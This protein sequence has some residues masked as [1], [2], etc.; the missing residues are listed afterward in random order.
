V[1]HEREM[2]RAL[3][4][5][6][7]GRGRVSPN[8][9]VGALVVRDGSVVAEG[10]HEGPGLAHA[11]AAALARAGDAARGATVYSTL[12]PCDHEGRTPPCTNALISAGVRRV[13][14][15][16]QDPNPLVDGG[17]IARL[18]RAGIDVVTGVLEDESHRLNEAFDKHVRTGLPF[19][20]LKMAAS[21]DGKV[22]ASDG[23]SRW[24][25]GPESRADA[26]A[27]RSVSDAIGVGAGTALADDPYL[28]ARDVPS[29]GRIPLRVLVDARGR[30]PA[31][32]NLFDGS[33]PTL[34]ATTQ[35]APAQRRA[36]WEEFGAQVLVLDEAPGGVDVRALMEALGK[37]DVQGLV[38]E[39]GP[40]LAWSFV[41]AGLI[42]KVILYLG[43]L[44]VGGSDA[45]TVLG[46]RGF[47]PL[48]EAL[49]LQAPSVRKL[50]D[51]LR[52]EAYVHR[53]R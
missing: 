26:H 25:S 2:A 45:P 21:L 5:A 17:G 8:P 43:A 50:G 46:G 16:A 31:T 7:R 35:R 20:T 40:T 47:A 37:R 34:V 14:V 4:L 51:D 22:A 13:V 23:T 1:E 39:G 32:G 15:A 27:L 42:D 10:W 49:R 48:A 24:I 53:D 9:M 36:D 18:R 6:A 19:A 11:E 44:L 12:E 28:T 30:V 29:T 3:R 33:A 38:L 41:Q 52:V